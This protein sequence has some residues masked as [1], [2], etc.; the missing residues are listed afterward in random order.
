MDESGLGLNL[1]NGLLE[2]MGSRLN[3]ISVYGEGSEFYFELEQAVL[4]PAP[5]GKLEL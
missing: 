1:A 4:D 5:I 3:L 2:L